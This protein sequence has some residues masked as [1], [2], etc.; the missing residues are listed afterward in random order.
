MTLMWVTL[1]AMAVIGTLFVILPL[2]TFRPR[3]ELSGNLINAAVFRDRLA[4]LDQDLVQQR[5]TEAEHTQLKQELE[6]TLLSDVDESSI[7][8]QGDKSGGKWMMLPV[9]ILVPLVAAFVYWSEGYR[10]ELSDWF[11]TQKRMQ[12]VIPLVM[13]GNFDAVEKEGVTVPDFIRMLQLQLQST[14][15]DAKGWYLLGASYL[16]A[17][18]PQ[19]AELAFNRAASLE[20][21][22]VD[23]V[24]GHIQA[25]LAGN[26]GSLT[27]EIRSTLQMIMQEQPNNPKPYM[28]M[29]M[30]LFQGGDFEAAVDIW[31]RY[32]QQPGADARASQLLQRSIDVARNQMENSAAP[33]TAVNNGPEIRVIVTVDP[34]IVDQLEPGSILFVY[35]KAQNGPPMPLAV[36]R[37]QIGDWPVQVTLSDANAMTPAMSL[38]KFDAV[39]VQARISASGNAIAQSGDWAASEMSLNLSDGAQQLELKID[40]RIP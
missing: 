26:G 23:Y 20:P 17:Q 34:G 14:P 31:E 24:M 12:D 15:D 37:Q 19:Q 39:R 16:Q 21:G 1:I 33:R 32:L 22:N 5:I 8:Q 29:G 10:S 3:Q 30:A 11:S 2:L 27:P 40:S 9:F 13:A 7:R 25:T 6:L 36:V 18:L 35:A 38:S 28:T 4:E